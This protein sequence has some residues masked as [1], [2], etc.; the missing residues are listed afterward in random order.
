MRERRIQARQMVAVHPPLL[1]IK[2]KLGIAGLG[3]LYVDWCDRTKRYGPP[4]ERGD[5]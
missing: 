4:C 1:L 2:V 5:L 3:R